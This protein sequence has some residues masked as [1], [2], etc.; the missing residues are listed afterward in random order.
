[1]PGQ[2]LPP[3]KSLAL[4]TVL[5][6]GCGQA[7]DEP[8]PGFA[9]PV[10]GRW[11]LTVDGPDGSYPSWLEIRLRTEL[12]LM[13]EFVGRSGSRR[14]ARSV[15]YSDGVLEVRI[16]TQYEAGTEHVFTGTLTD[17]RLAGRTRIDDGPALPWSGVRA[18]PLVRTGPAAWGAPVVMIGDDLAGW[19]RRSGEHPGCW[20]VDDGILSATPP[21]VDLVSDALFDDFRLELEFRYP[22][23]SNSGVYLRGRYEV[24]I[25]DDRG[26][27]V[28]P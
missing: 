28:D 26:K 5:V 4:A 27:A 3:L 21:C 14:F 13:A 11:D 16:P 25:Q 15:D 9:D 19:R 18:P 7:A 24:Q 2:L 23:G 17:D 22:P 12:S 8:A 10:L 1:M 6:A 20:R